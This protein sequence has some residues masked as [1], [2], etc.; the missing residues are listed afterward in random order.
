MRKE[1]GGETHEEGGILAT[2]QDG[3]GSGSGRIRREQYP[4]RGAPMAADQL[5]I[6]PAG[7]T[8]VVTF[9]D[10]L[11]SKARHSTLLCRERQLSSEL[12]KGKATSLATVG[13]VIGFARARALCTGPGPWFVP[14]VSQRGEGT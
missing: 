4:Q 9:F 6:A 5:R 12:P 8:H 1:F 11:D 2:V 14:F 3:S 13:G 10:D 7:V